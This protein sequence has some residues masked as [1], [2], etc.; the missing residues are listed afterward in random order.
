MAQG[1]QRS[2]DAQGRVGARKRPS[3]QLMAA[4]GPSVSVFLSDVETVCF[5]YPT[6]FHATTCLGLPCAHHLARL[7]QDHSASAPTSTRHC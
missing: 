6:S 4:L 1:L 7:C 5:Y 2:L 3:D